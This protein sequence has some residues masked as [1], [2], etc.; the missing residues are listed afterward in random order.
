MKKIISVCLIAAILM[1]LAACGDAT[2]TPI[3]VTPT[4]IQV[5]TTIPAT[6]LIPTTLPIVSTITPTP[7]PA[8]SPVFSSEFSPKA[9]KRVFL[10]ILE[11]TDY[12]E[13]IRQ[14]YLGQLAG[15]GALLKNYFAVTH[16]SY[17]NYLALVGGS[18]FGV[19][20]DGQTDLDKSN[21]ADLMDAAGISWKV[22]A[23]GLPTTPCYK[24]VLSGDYARKHEPFVSFLNVQNNP[25]R[26]ANIVPA[27]RLQSDITANSLAHYILYVPDQKND[28]HDTGPKYTS[29][30]LQGFL[31]PMLNNPQVSQGTLFVVTFDEGLA[32]SSNQVYTVLAGDMV[33]AGSSSDKR[34]THYDLLRTIEDNFQLGNLGREDATA[35]PISGIWNIAR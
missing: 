12:S 5:Q 17:P 13:A 15:K 28:G 19:T 14:T 10:I 18:T 11:N 9:F 7:I 31:P 33:K 16:P 8:T 24:G 3:A 6:T 4:Q 34:Y 32:G 35:T 23:E 20:S 26:C 1:I 22:Y 29:T 21:L 25:N 27:S 30:W 2:A